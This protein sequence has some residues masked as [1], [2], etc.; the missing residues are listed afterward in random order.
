MQLPCSSFGGK[1]FVRGYAFSGIYTNAFIEKKRERG[2][3]TTTLTDTN[4]AISS[5]FT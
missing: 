5:W 1:S 4:N 3:L 2:S